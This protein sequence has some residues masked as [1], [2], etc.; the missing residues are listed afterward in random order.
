[1]RGEEVSG[2]KLTKTTRSVRLGEIERKWYLVD[3]DGKVLGRLA[4]EIAQIL[5]GKNKG[6]FTPNIDCGDHVIVINASK[7]KVTGGKEG[8]KNYYHYSGFPSGLKEIPY[9][10]LQRERPEKVVEFAVKGMLPHNKLGRRMLEKLHVYPGS[11]HP[12]EAQKPQKLE[13]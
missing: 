9:S 1:M 3:A 12:H 8:K 4:S 10:R 7:L 5:R 2:L 11:S 13:V 6:E